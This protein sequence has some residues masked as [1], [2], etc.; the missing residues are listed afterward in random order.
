MAKDE[1]Q[2]AAAD[3][4]ATEEDENPCPPW[5]NPLHHKGPDFEN[6][7]FTDG[8]YVCL[9]FVLNPLACPC[10]HDVNFYLRDNTL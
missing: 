7:V 3:D 9:E 8:A 2:S 10:P 6:K 4:G 1:A 5:Q